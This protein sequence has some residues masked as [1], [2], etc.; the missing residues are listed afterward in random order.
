MLDF[1]FLVD[2]FSSQHNCLIQHVDLKTS[3]TDVYTLGNFNYRVSKN[4]I[5][6]A[7]IM[8][9]EEYIFAPTPPFLSLTMLCFYP[10]NKT[11]Y[12]SHLH[13]SL[14]LSYL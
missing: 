7:V 1:Y 12:H 11:H 4:S 6:K 3:Q 8:W 13:L 14:F 9:H 10:V 5:L 2:I